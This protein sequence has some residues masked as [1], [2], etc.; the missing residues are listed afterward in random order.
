MSISKYGSIFFVIFSLLICGPL[1]F[2]A[3]SD[4]L[5]IKKSIQTEADKMI[6]V[7]NMVLDPVLPVALIGSKM[8]GQVNFMT[9]AWFT[10]LEVDPYLF[11]VSIQKQHFT[12]AAIMKNKAFSINIPTTEMIPKVDAVGMLS[13]REYDKSE[14]FDIFYGDNENVP[15][16]DGSIISIECKLVNTVSLVERDEKHPRAHSLIIGEV[17]NVWASKAT[18]DDKGLN[19][20]DYGPVYWSWSPMSYWSIGDKVAQAWNGENRKLVPKKESSSQAE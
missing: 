4:P 3:D 19:F 7:E 15:M 10:R 16:V 11:G 14:V 12:H 18:L 9:A 8:D 5:P 20:K 6:K 13:G 1:I 17:V 2:A